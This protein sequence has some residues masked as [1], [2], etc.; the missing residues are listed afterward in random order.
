MNR[1][2]RN[3]HRMINTTLAHFDE[4]PG[5]WTDLRPL[6]TEVET[7]RTVRDRMDRAAG[8]KAASDTRGHTREKTAARDHAEALLTE[9]SRKV[10]PYAKTAGDEPLLQAV[11]R[12]P[13]DWGRL[14]DADLVTEATDAIDRTEAVLPD[15]VDYEV[16]ADDL[17]AARAAVARVPRLTETR[18][19]VGADQTTAVADLDALYS[20][21][22]LPALG[23]LDDLVPALV[24]DADFVA[25]YAV[26][27]RIPGD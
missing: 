13:T 10:R 18:D 25:Q 2:L 26:V 5:L 6:S 24:D 11:D 16:S 27:R 21:H 1:R 20:D 3:R 23:R 9:L 7:L 4:H 19:N 12:S 17:A 22:A 14:P 8:Q 15:L